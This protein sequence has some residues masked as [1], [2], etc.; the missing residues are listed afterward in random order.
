M[1]FSG[2]GGVAM[3]PRNRALLRA[4]VP[5]ALMGVIFFF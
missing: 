3:N 5:I 2:P 4:L 1:P